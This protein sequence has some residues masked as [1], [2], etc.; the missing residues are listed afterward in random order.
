MSAAAA[1]SYDQEVLQVPVLTLEAV[2]ARVRTYRPDLDVDRV[3]AAAELGQEFSNVQLHNPTAKIRHGFT[4][5]DNEHAALPPN[6]VL[7]ASRSGVPLKLA[8]TLL[9]SS[10]GT[11]RDPT[12]AEAEFT[13]T[14]QATARAR[15][16]GRR[17]TPKIVDAD[18]GRASLLSTDP[19]TAKRPLGFYA[20]LLGLPDPDRSGAVR[21]RRALDDLAARRLIWLDRSN[22][23]VPRTQL[24]REDGTGQDYSAPWETKLVKVDEKTVVPQAEGNYFVLPATFWTSGWAAALSTRA[25]AA[26]AVLQVQRKLSSRGPAFITPSVRE[27]LYGMREDTFLRGIGELAFFELVDVGKK[28]VKPRWE[29][30]RGRYRHTF[31]PHNTALSHSPLEFLEVGD[32]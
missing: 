11:G 8:I 17:H 19:Y 3:R 21:I 16:R 14:E 18:A 26:F 30:G 10:T 28:A 12:Y 15:A 31:A 22:G 29:P 25:I 1:R 6:A 20:Q 4:R 27:N 13:P 23:V 32:E 7:C 5:R 9:W 24:R 2:E